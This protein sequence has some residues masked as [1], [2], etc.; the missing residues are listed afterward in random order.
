MSFLKIL[1]GVLFTVLL[2]L[3]SVSFIVTVFSFTVFIFQME[4]KEV[5][6]TF[7]FSGVSTLILNFSMISLITFKKGLNKQEKIEQLKQTMKKLFF[8]LINLF[9]SI[10]YS[11]IYFMLFAF[12]TISEFD[13]GGMGADA[14]EGILLG[15]FI[16]L[17]I[18]IYL[19]S[20]VMLLKTHPHNITHSIYIEFLI[21]KWSSLFIFIA[22]IWATWYFYHTEGFTGYLAMLIWDLIFYAFYKGLSELSR[23]V[24][25]QIKNWDSHIIQHLKKKEMLKKNEKDEKR[26]AQIKACPFCG[27][28]ILSIAIK[29]KHCG[30]IIE[31]DINKT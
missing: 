31:K 15:F 25:R 16:S 20:I 21:L 27:E 23:R 17:T 9:I 8:S 2:F 6:Y 13:K 7:I 28:E 19:I 14:G 5:L 30:S 26:E 3:S 24:L 12:I 29:C 10:I 22:G 1:R 4:R 18:V 11:F